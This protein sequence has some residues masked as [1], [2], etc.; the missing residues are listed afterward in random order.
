LKDVIAH[1]VRL[2]GRGY[3]HDR[4]SSS[5]TRC[6]LLCPWE[7]WYPA[8]KEK[9]E[10]HDES[11]DEE[12]LDVAL[13]YKSDIFKYLYHKNIN[14]ESKENNLTAVRDILYVMG[15][16]NKDTIHIFVNH[17]KSRADGQKKTEA[18]R[19]YSAKILK[20]AINEIIDKNKKA[21]IIVMGD[22]NDE[23]TD[24]SIFKSLDA[25][26]RRKNESNDEL[27]NPYYDLNNTTNEG[28]I[29]YNDKWQLFDQIM[30]SQGL[31]KSSKGLFFGYG[32]PN[33]FKADWLLTK[34]SKTGKLIPKQTF[35]NK[36]YYGGYSNHLP[37]YLIFD[38][39]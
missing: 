13:L 16:I 25:T 14:V 27:Y 35:M 8:P 29:Y 1:T 36:N 31:I 24:K 22:F 9:W 3:S 15:I 37:V 18:A 2:E 32:K 28:T 39:K 20:K 30:V 12:G 23:P 17:W 7:V 5:T 34:D 33:I 4:A 21:K 11:P 38:I 10:R 19:I 26:N 6:H